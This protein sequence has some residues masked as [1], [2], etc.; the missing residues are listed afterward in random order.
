M[1]CLNVRKKCHHNFSIEFTR[2][3]CRNIGSELIEVKHVN[4]V[5]AGLKEYPLFQERAVQVSY[6]NKTTRTSI[7]FWCAIF[8]PIFARIFRF[9]TKS[10][11]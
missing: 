7:I 10:V 1:H 4:T 2:T 9:H 8:T 5:P 3:I 6:S 11:K